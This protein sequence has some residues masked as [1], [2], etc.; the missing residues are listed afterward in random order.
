MCA[1]WT[2][3]WLLGGSKDVSNFWYAMLVVIIYI[4]ILFLWGFTFF[5]LF[6][7][8]DL[9]GWSKALWALAIIFLPIIGVLGYFITRPSGLDA[10]SGRT[11]QR[12]APGAQTSAA[13]QNI[14]TLTQLHDDGSLSDDEFAR[15]MGR[16]AG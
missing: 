10:Y 14:D 7:R 1:R 5:D 9:H 11:Y 16:V 13:V 15:L 6:R 12:I 2:G 4:P 3:Y 8:K